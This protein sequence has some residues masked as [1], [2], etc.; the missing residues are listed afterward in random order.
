MAEMLNNDTESP[1]LAIRLSPPARRALE[2][3]MMLGGFETI[4]E[5]LRHAISDQLFLLKERRSGSTV[6]L[7]RG[8][9]DR[10][11]VWPGKG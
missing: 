5:A 4:Y 3:I 1:H 9:I 11:I 8:D 10:E 6:M 2:E 7:R